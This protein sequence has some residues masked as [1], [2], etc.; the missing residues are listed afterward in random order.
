MS[1]HTIICSPHDRREPYQGSVVPYLETNKFR[2]RLLA[3]Q[4]TRPFPYRVKVLG[5]ALLATRTDPN[6]FWMFLSG[7]AEIIF[8]STTANFPLPVIAAAT[9]NAALFP[10]DATGAFAAANV[11]TPTACLKR[12]ARPSSLSGSME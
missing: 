12:K 10:A 7:N 4:K 11:T 9:S 6:L 1:I 2:P 3:I 8:Q 5:R